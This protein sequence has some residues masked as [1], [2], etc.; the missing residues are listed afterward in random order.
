M[1]LNF[2]CSHGDCLRNRVG[3][4]GGF[5]ERL[6][7]VLDHAKDILFP[8]HKVFLAVQLALDVMDGQLGGAKGVGHGGSGLHLHGGA[9]VEVRD[10]D[11]GDGV[12]FS[13]HPV[14]RQSEIPGSWF[15]WLVTHLWPSRE[16]QIDFGF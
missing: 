1:E 5:F 2:L 16:T 14:K 8:H 11:V 3:L 9:A 13:G 15:C 6:G 10:A 4:S 7:T 12:E